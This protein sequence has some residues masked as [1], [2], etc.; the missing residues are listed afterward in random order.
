LQRIGKKAVVAYVRYSKSS[1]LANVEV[2]DVVARI[3]RK[4]GVD[5]MKKHSECKKGNIWELKKISK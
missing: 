5:F 3:Q 4:H 2:A 1:A